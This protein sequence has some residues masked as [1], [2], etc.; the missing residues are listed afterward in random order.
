MSAHVSEADELLTRQY[1]ELEVEAHFNNENYDEL[2]KLSSEYLEN[3]QRTSSGKWKLSILY[4]AFSIIASE[5]GTHE[6][7]WTNVMNK[8]DAW[9]EKFPNSSTA[10]IAKGLLLSSYAW[11]VSDYEYTRYIP[12][13]EWPD[14]I[15]Q[16][17]AAK[18]YMNEIKDKSDNNPGWYL[19]MSEIIQ[20]LDAEEDEYM[21]MI[22]EGLD[23]HPE[24][25]PI[26]FLAIDYYGKMGDEGIKK[27]E[28]FV[29]SSVKRTKDIEG[30][31]LYARLYWY[32][33]QSIYGS[34]LFNLSDAIWPNM[35]EGISDVLKKYPDQWNI[36]NFAYY[37]CLVKDQKMT[38]ELMGKIDKP[39]LDDVWK[40]QEFYN[41]CQDWAKG[42]S[43]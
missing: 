33:Y 14:F 38:E 36:N 26:Y 21:T 31:A 10:R 17:N 19:V 6:V 12:K 40:T 43:L 11:R 8:S 29:N 27:I 34:N 41:N 22:N 1:I 4:H 2:E 25:Y 16:L 39:L 9:I 5:A 32:A 42:T 3:K 18:Q 15:D 24:F 37:A 28:V 7:R 30:K 13:E 20:G 35:K 23:K